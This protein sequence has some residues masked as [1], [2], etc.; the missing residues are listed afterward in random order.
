MQCLVQLKFFLSNNIYLR[1]LIDIKYIPYLNYIFKY[2]YV[3]AF[4]KMI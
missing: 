3:Y 1:H 2:A 4:V